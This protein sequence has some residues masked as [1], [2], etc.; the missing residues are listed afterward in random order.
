MV[1]HILSCGFHAAGLLA[2]NT[3]GGPARGSHEGSRKDAGR[4]L[5]FAGQQRLANPKWLQMPNLALC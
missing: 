1:L 4:G 5:R 2:R 3:Y